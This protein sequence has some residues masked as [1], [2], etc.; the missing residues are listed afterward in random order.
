MILKQWLD[1]TSD[2]DTCFQKT[3][4]SKA[5]TLTIRS[6]LQLLGFLSWIY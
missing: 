5:L 2:S 1:L 3:E 4:Q 6:A